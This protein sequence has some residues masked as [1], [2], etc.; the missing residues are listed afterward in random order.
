MKTLFKLSEKAGLVPTV[1]G[2]IAWL[3]CGTVATIAVVDALWQSPKLAFALAMVGAVVTGFGGLIGYWLVADRIDFWRLGYQVKWLNANYWFY[4]ERRA[5]SEER[6]LPYL[7][8][9]RGQGYPAPCT[10]RI[11]SQAD[12]ESEAPSWARG[13]RSEI[14]ERIA[15]CHG[16]MNG[17][18]VQI[19]N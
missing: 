1:I 5:T 19:L 17:G 10:V 11:L 8:E 6:I 15:N 4:E 12:W 7:L 14:V 3:A 2:A 9:I 13:R 18:D 16:A